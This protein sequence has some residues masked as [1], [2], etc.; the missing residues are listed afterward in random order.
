MSRRLG[1]SGLIPAIH[2]ERSVAAAWVQGERSQP[3]ES[4]DPISTAAM[5][6]PCAGRSELKECTQFWE[7][8][9]E[10]MAAVAGDSCAIAIRVSTKLFHK[11]AVVPGETKGGDWCNR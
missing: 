9:V 8:E 2:F 3:G 6:G 10:I 7:V 1:V 11:A 4:P 5:T